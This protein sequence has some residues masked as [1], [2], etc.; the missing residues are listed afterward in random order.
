[1][2]RSFAVGRRLRVEQSVEVVAG[3]GMSRL[4]DEDCS[5]HWYECVWEASGIVGCISMSIGVEDEEEEEEERGKEERET[6]DAPSVALANA[7]RV[8]EAS[9]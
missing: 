5:G 8:E 2:S 7:N 3:G 6:V 1:M 9:D 4:C